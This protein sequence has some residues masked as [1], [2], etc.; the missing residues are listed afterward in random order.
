MNNALIITLILLVL[1]VLLFTY[2]G[3]KFSLKTRK[4]KGLTPYFLVGIFIGIIGGFLVF[5]NLEI[6]QDKVYFSIHFNRWWFITIVSIIFGT[7]LSIYVY[8][9]ASKK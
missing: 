1:L 3:L 2:I 8:L 9:R 6:G 4:R 7:V 5:Y